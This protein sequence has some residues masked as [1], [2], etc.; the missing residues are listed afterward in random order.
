MEKLPGESQELR[1]LTDHQNLQG[2][3]IMISQPE[4]EAAV[5]EFALFVYFSFDK[6]H[7]SACSERDPRVETDT[8]ANSIPGP[9]SY[10]HERR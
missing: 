5:A 9:T 8:R 6:A 4:G 7:Q 10:L 2:R 3:F 1:V